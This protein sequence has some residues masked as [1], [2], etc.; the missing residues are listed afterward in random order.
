MTMKNKTNTKKKSA[1]HQ[2]AKK[3]AEQVKPVKKM[4]TEYYLIPQE[5]SISQ[6][7]ELL[8]DY[9][10]KI[11]L[12]LEMDLMELTLT[13]DT[14]VFE[15]AAEDFANSEDQVYFAEHKI[16]KV[17][18]ITYD[19]LDAEEVRQ[20]LSTLQA[21]LQ[22]RVCEEDEILE[23]SNNMFHL[24]T[25]SNGAYSISYVAHRKICHFFEKNKRKT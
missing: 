16:K 21:V 12:W 6:M 10:E 9:Q 19:A 2:T 4:L 7:A 20:I 11:E 17:Y 8:P 23:D 3:S 18:A 24:R 25:V 22:G 15:E 1:H 13:H 14:M 5:T